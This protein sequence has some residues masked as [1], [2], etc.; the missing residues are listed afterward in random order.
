VT[1]KEERD[2]TM[3]RLAVLES[4]MEDERKAT[5]QFNEALTDIRAMKQNID[6][7][8]VSAKQSSIDEKLRAKK[9]AEHDTI[10][11][12][13]HD[14]VE[15]HTKELATLQTTVSDLKTNGVTISTKLAV[16]GGIGVV[17]ATMALNQGANYIFR[18]LHP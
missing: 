7:L 2:S 3:E 9:C 15:A 4:R 5:A 11:A 6:W 18:M 17:V 13:M 16:Y 8:V 14:L 10:V 1:I 12:V